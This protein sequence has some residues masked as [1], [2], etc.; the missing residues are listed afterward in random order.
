LFNTL[1][2][3]QDDNDKQVIA[4]WLHDKAPE[5]QRIYRSDIA[6]F[7]TFVG[8]PLN[9]I[10][11]GD[12]RAFAD[13]LKCASATKARILAAIKSLFAFAK[14]IDYIRFDVSAAIKLPKVKKILGK[15][16]IGEGDVTKMIALEPDARNRVMLKLLYV[17]GIRVSELC[18][19]AWC[20]VQ[21]AEDSTYIT[22]FGKGGKTRTIT[23]DGCMHRSLVSIRGKSGP[24]EP[25]FK[26]HKKGFLDPSQVW[27]IVRAA[28]K[29]ADIDADV[30]PNWLRHAHASHSLDQV[31]PARLKCT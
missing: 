28:A 3:K 26:S 30:S 16:A 13:T 27:R 29:R 9:E 1:T 12:V 22:V 8:K 23:V 21:S 5:T 4:M 11:I 31:C 24:D 25:V 18:R 2:V 17:T 10:T 15:K 6:R 14:R 20:N 7:L 19:L